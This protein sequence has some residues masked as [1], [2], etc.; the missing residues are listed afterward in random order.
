MD[1]NK[2]VSVLIE[3]AGTIKRVNINHC[4]KVKFYLLHISMPAL[5]VV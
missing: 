2:R 3:N 1:V 4:V 5:K